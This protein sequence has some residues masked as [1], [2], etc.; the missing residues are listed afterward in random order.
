[1]SKILKPHLVLIALKSLVAKIRTLNHQCTRPQ[2]PFI[3]SFGDITSC[4]A[5]FIFF[6]KQR[7]QLVNMG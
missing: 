2:I 5:F 4:A 1:M 6:Y 3:N 7:P